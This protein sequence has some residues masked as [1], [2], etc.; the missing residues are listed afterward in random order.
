MLRSLIAGISGLTQFQGRMDVIGNNIA[1]VNTTGFKAAS[2]NFADAFSQTMQASSASRDGNSG[3]AA[4][5]IGSGVATNAIKNIFTQGALTRTGVSTDL[6]VQGNGYFVVKDTLTQAQ[7]AT[8]AGDFRL[9]DNNNLITNT[10]HRVQGYN[11]AE[12]TSFGDIQIDTVG[13]P[14]TSDPLAMKTSYSIGDDGKVTVNLSD[15]TNFVRGQILL[16]SFN[17]QSALVKEGDNLYSG[18]STA[19]MLEWADPGNPGRPGVGSLGNIK[20]GALE[21]SNVELGNEFTNLITTQRAYQASARI[22]TTSDEM[23]QELVNL[24]R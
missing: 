1:N 10:G 18:M 15:G 23:L 11:N 7:F 12:L 16:Q 14:A 5:Q 3:T 22:I 17:D 13:L 21:L 6:A 2:T 4:M 20:A 8:R 9:D 19:G 24:K